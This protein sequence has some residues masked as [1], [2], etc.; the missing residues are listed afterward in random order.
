MKQK[1]PELDLSSLEENVWLIDTTN[2]EEVL[3]NVLSGDLED[4]LGFV[5]SNC[6][7][8]IFEDHFSFLAAQNQP[9]LSETLEHRLILASLVRNFGPLELVSLSCWVDCHESPSVLDAGA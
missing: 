8:G 3:N 6:I 7:W 4:P 5:L 9:T 1:R 2:Y